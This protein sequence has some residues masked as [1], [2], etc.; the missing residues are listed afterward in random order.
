MFFFKNNMDNIEK[1]VKLYHHCKIDELPNSLLDNK[2]FMLKR[3]IFFNKNNLGDTFHPLNKFKHDYDLIKSI[4]NLKLKDKINYLKL[5]K[6]IKNVYNNI[7]SK[8]FKLL[9]KIAKKYPLIFYYINFDIIKN[10]KKF[11]KNIHSLCDD[12]YYIKYIIKNTLNYDEEFLY[13][14]KKNVINVNNK[15]FI[16]D[17]IKNGVKFE[18]CDKILMNLLFKRPGYHKN[19]CSEYILYSSNIKYKKDEGI[20]IKSPTYYLIKYGKIKKNNY[21]KLNNI[22]L[23]K[24]ENVQSYYNY[25][26][27]LC[28]FSKKYDLIY[29]LLKKYIENNPYFNITLLL[30][31]FFI[32]KEIIKLLLRK[33]NNN[34]YY[35]FKLVYN[36]QKYYQLLEK[37]NNFNLLI[38][39]IN[40]LNNFGIRYSKLIERTNINT[41][42]KG[43]DED[44]GIFISK[45]NEMFKYDKKILE[46][47]LYHNQKAIKNI[48]IIYKENIFSNLS[49]F[50]DKNNNIN[51]MDFYLSKFIN[52]ENVKLRKIP[53]KLMNNENL[54]IFK[55]IIRN[56]NFRSFF[57]FEQENN[58]K[59]IMKL[60]KNGANLLYSIPH[61]KNDHD[62][63]LKSLEND[64]N[65][66]LYCN[67]KYINKYVEFNYDINKML[68][69][70]T[71]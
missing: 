31:S 25:L 46:K 68:L 16:F 56:I 67:V 53:K 62:I 43:I 34:S 5:D 23:K 7:L 17:F 51:K 8:D 49:C 24:L 37:K 40:N 22:L 57:N 48:D 21:N 6:I 44:Y 10:K 54:N 59:L 70:L 3:I 14:L 12:Y 13:F 1:L 28:T 47:I 27:K 36:S 20:S 42:I 61:F 33:I 26:V 4:F 71:T 45:L 64:E 52:H 19:K 65:M 60:L 9:F 55:K 2:D 63:V 32:K 58:K 35:L 66:I 69:Y 18:T 39:S 41:I 30:K 15:D 29:L 50:I 11:N 38:Y